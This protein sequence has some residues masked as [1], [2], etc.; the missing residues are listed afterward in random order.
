V[1]ST[2][3][4]AVNINTSTGDFV[5]T[6][7]SSNGAAKGITVTALTGGGSFTVNGTGGNCQSSDTSCTGGTIQGGTTRGAEFSNAVG[8]TL[9]NMYFKGNGTTA[10]STGSGCVD[11]NSA[12]GSNVACNAALHLVNATTTTLSTVYLD[13]TGSADMGL[14]GNA[15]SGLTVNGLEI[16]NFSGNQKDAATLQNLTGTVGFTGLNVHN[17]SL[18]HNF[19]V[20]NVSGTANITFTSPVINTS[21]FSGSG[22][23]DGIQVVSYVSANV[24]VTATNINISNVAGTSVSFQANSGSTM[25]ATLSGGTSTLNNGILMQSAGNNTN[26]T[27]TVTG[28]TSVTTLP[29]G[30]NAI[31]VGKANGTNGTAVG[32]VTNNVITFSPF[33]GINL[34]SYGTSGVSSVTVTGNNISNVNRA[35]SATA[36][37]GANSF[38]VVIQ[39]NTIGAPTA[40]TFAYAIDIV[41]GTQ[42]GDGHCLFLNL[43]DMS[44]GHTVPANRN[45]ISTTGWQSGGNPIELAQFNNS[46][47][48]ILNYPGGGDAGA[49]SWTTAS[50]TIAGSLGTD[51]FHLAPSTG[52]TSGTSCP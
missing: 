8:V 49:A 5:F 1:T 44:V 4:T 40:G 43:G 50:N 20:S 30:S 52:F 6:K 38:N 10:I 19:F 36:G 51:A 42:A 32:T 29:L 47:F 35:I 27:Y 18:A 17:N 26:F 12:G 39:G 24:T 46:T 22:N 23:A 21:P 13:G 11:S 31:T 16:A 41:D 7:V 25:V 48:K 28:L 14:N 15:V 33:D 34:N 37:Q 45:N 3:G 2:T 9:N